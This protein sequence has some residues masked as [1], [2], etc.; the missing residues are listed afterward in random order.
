MNAETVYGA[1]L[2]VYIIVFGFWHTLRSQQTELRD[3]GFL[4]STQEKQ[5]DRIFRASLVAGAAFVASLGAWALDLLDV[6]IAALIAGG[7]TTSVY[8]IRTRRNK[9]IA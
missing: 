1:L 7:V 5:D 3:K 6:A 8:L 4:H 9:P 2:M